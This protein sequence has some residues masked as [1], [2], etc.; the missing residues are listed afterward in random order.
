MVTEPLLWISPNGVNPACPE[1]PRGQFVLRSATLAGRARLEVRQ[2]GRLLQSAH[3]RLVPG[4]SIRLA[5]QWARH[6]DPAG[7]PVQ[8]TPV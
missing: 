3:A 4:R 7:G 5:G 1:P 8:V 6:V 2:D